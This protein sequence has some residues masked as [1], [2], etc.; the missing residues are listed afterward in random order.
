MRRH[1][2]ACSKV[3]ALLLP[4]TLG[5]SC[6][7]RDWTLCSPKDKC[8]PG[9]ACTADWHCVAPADAGSDGLVAVDSHDLPDA[10]G[11][12]LDGPV[13]AGTDGPGGGATGLDG[14]EPDRAPTPPDAPVAPV[15]DAPAASLPD[16]PPVA[17]PADAAIPDAPTVDAPGTCSTDRDCPS[18]SPLCLNNRCAKCSGDSDCTGRT[19]PACAGS[20]LCVACTASKHCTGAAGTCDTPSHQC[21]GCLTRSDCANPCQACTSGVCTAVINQ[22]DTDRCAGTCDSTGA[23]KNKRG[24]SCKANSDCVGG[25]SCADGICCDKACTGSCQACDVEGS[26]GI[27]TALASGA[28]PRHSACGGTGVCAGSCG[29]KTDGSCS[30][31]TVACGS[32]TC[33]GQT[34]QAAGTCNAG[35][36]KSPDPLP[37]SNACSTTAGCTGECRPGTK[38]CSGSQPQICDPDGAWQNTGNAC[39]GCYT[40]SAAT[41]ACVANTGNLCDDGNACTKTDTCQ[42]GVCVG[43]NSKTC[44]TPPV[45]RGAG[46]CDP[47]TGDCNYPLAAKDSPCNDNNACT[48][49]DSCQGG[50]CTGT[51][52]SCNSPPACHVAGA[53]SAGT[54]SYPKA[55]D[56][57]TDSSCPGT[58]RMCYQGTCVGCLTDQQCSGIRPSCDPSTHT[59]V[60]R[61]PSSGNL[62]RNPGFDGSLNEW[63]AWTAILAADSEGCSGSNSVYVDNDEDAPQQCVT[64][65]GGTAPTYYFGGQF[66]GGYTGNFFRLRFFTGAN[67]TGT[68][69]NTLNLDLVGSPDWAPL[70]MYFV[71]P[72]GTASVRVGFY[73]MQQYF[74]Q[75]YLN[76]ANQF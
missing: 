75:L 11:G 58:T 40:C 3:M 25:T 74:D 73:G 24:Q 39:S 38:Q 46:V 64:L 7:E 19:G 41:G 30:Y 52:I 4:A 44:P 43:S 59:C 16:G 63:T 9:Y 57:T 35:N 6:L 29:G 54:C 2:V 61:R 8:K 22:D 15:S 76:V 18:Q 53:C 42:S 49:F 56:G 31:P 26:L 69:D 37:C 65:T 48:Q 28:T 5:L 1:Y 67:C 62:L 51:A 14:P 10:A 12:G 45:C 68:S 13:L 27:C 33:V 23:C 66:K 47:S 50:V 21:V 17:S 72:S 71:A 70:S 60:C 20:G 36:C 32:A 55:D 34:Y